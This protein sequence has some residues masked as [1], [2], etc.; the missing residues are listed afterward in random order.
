ML[1]ITTLFKVEVEQVSFV[2]VHIPI[3][4]VSILYLF[5]KDT[6]GDRR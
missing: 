6:A 2:L 3:H 4:V 5:V 1:D